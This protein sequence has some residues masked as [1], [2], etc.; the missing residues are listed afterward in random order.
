MIFPDLTDASYE[1]TRKSDPD[2]KFAK[3]RH[4]LSSQALQWPLPSPVAW[5]ILYTNIHNQPTRPIMSIRNLNR[6]Q[7]SLIVT[8]CR[9]NIFIIFIKFFIIFWKKNFS[10]IFLIKFFT[11][12]FTDFGS[13]MIIIIK[14]FSVIYSNKDRW[15]L[16]SKFS[17]RQSFI[18]MLIKFL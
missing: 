3:N 6:T 2:F 1:T 4:S 7:I 8:S 18:G 9:N 17:P 11:Y 12:F 5:Y 15:S 13:Q 14:D 16:L 10:I